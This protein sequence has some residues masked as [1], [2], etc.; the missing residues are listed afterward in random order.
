MEAS[1]NVAR[2]PGQPRHPSRERE[3]P[4][5]REALWF[6]VL[7]E[8]AGMIR[9]TA[10]VL[11]ILVTPPFSWGHEFVDQ[12]WA[13]ARR[14]FVPLALAAFAI[15]FGAGTQAG[16]VNASFGAIDRLGLQFTTGVVREVAPFITGI[17]LAGVAGTAICADLGARRVREEIDA[18]QVMGVDVFRSVVVPRFLAVG[19]LTGLMFLVTTFFC[20]LAGVVVTTAVFQAPVAGYLST[21]Q[22][23]FVVLD[24]VA[25]LLKTTAFGFMIGT[26]CC[27]KGLNVKSGGAEAVSRAVNQAV[28]IAFV[29]IFVFNYAWTSIQLAAFPELQQVR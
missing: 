27:Y 15:G 16:I 5:P 1:P 9:F 10:S 20:Q 13:M 24:L 11:R 6:R 12:S 7:A 22:T 19:L 29:A 2:V 4:E 23:N 17:L 14:C 26:V 18:L 3:E 8:F 28:V 21:F 25:A